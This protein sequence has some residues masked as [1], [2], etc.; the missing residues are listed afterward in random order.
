MN[1]GDVGDNSHE[2]DNRL[3]REPWNSSGANVVD[4]IKHWAEGIG[5]PLNLSLGTLWPI[6]RVWNDLNSDWRWHGKW[7]SGG[8]ANAGVERLAT[9]GLSTPTDFIVSP[10]HRFVRPFESTRAD[11]LHQF[12]KKRMLCLP[13]S[14]RRITSMLQLHLVVL[15]QHFAMVA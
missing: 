10:L 5:K 8:W 12:A 4:S 3:C 15:V 6:C 1:E 7:H 11:A 13:I 14:V 2:I 9:K